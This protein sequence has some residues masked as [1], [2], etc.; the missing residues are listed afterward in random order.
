MCELSEAT[1]MRSHTH[2]RLCITYKYLNLVISMTDKIR[3]NCCVDTVDSFFFSFITFCS[4]HVSN[5]FFFTV[6]I[7]FSLCHLF[8]S[9]SF[10]SFT[11]FPHILSAPLFTASLNQ[12]MNSEASEIELK[13][14]N[15]WCFAGFEIKQKKNCLHLLSSWAGL[16]DFV[17]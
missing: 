2:P 9:A 15:P 12:N 4:F 8:H 5:A 16:V 3:G 13:C 1:H 11:S 10:Y 7:Y 14:S 17:A 6:S